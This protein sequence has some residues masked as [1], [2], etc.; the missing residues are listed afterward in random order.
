LT[1]TTEDTLQRIEE[2]N[3]TIDYNELFKEETSS[4]AIFLKF[5]KQCELGLKEFIQKENLKLICHFY[6]E[7]DFEIRT[8]EKIILHITF[9]NNQLEFEEILA[10][11]DQIDKIIREKINQLLNKSQEPD[12]EAIRNLNR[13]FFIDI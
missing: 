6:I 9:E 10:M 3:L 4:N 12:R 1:K 11:W 7:R 13:K 5:I 2:K 8:W